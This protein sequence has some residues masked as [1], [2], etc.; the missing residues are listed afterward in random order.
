VAPLHE[1]RSATACPPLPH[2]ELRQAGEFV[3]FG[4][5][6]VKLSVSTTATDQ[7][8]EPS[9]AIDTVALFAAE[10]VWARRV[11]PSQGAGRVSR[12]PTRRVPEPVHARYTE[13]FI[14]GTENCG[15]SREPVPRRI[16]TKI[17]A[18]AGM[19]RS[20]KSRDPGPGAV[21]FRGPSVAAEP[22]AP[23]DVAA[24]ASGRFAESHAA[25]TS[26]AEAASATEK[27]LAE[28]LTPLFSQ[29]EVVSPGR[30][31]SRR[32][33]CTA[34]RGAMHSRASSL[35]GTAHRICR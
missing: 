23:T 2:R 13:Y 10:M 16:G 1:F 27:H 25:T 6:N 4:V 30:D 17:R 34:G 26:N 20:G 11:R 5:A 24:P 18:S 29:P 15:V 31:H 32:P 9:G 21:L 8:T 3:G 33:H 28:L 35:H 7:R 14:R 22:A 12:S 19:S